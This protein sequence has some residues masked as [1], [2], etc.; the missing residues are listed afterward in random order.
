MPSA[1]AKSAPRVRRRSGPPTT[2]AR[3]A[4]SPI[5]SSLFLRARPRSLTLAKTSRPP[6]VSATGL[7]RAGPL[8][9][10][11]LAASP[12]PPSSTLPAGIL[13]DDRTTRQREER[14]EGDWSG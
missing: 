6:P 11:A 10:L 7:I 14:R 12:A 3:I 9:R 8:E 5:V 1:T 4:G 2:R 13:H